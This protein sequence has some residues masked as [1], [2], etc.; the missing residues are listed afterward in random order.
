MFAQAIKRGYRY[1]YVCGSVINNQIS[2]IQ[3]LVC[4]C[5]ESTLG[6]TKK[7]CAQYVCV[8]VHARWWVA[9]GVCMRVCNLQFPV[10]S[11]LCVYAC[12]CVNNAELLHLQ[13]AFFTVNYEVLRIKESHILIKLLHAPLSISSLPIAPHKGNHPASLTNRVSTFQGWCVI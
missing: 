9:V 13:K 8:F 10:N 3:L 5:N 11:N 4:V 1:V 12:I 6:S 2:S 7:K